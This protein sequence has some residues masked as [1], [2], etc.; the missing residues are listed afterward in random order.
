MG[1]YCTVEAKFD[2]KMWFNKLH[3]CAKFHQKV[4]TSHEKAPT[5]FSNFNFNVKLSKNIRSAYLPTS[6]S[7]VNVISCISR[8]DNDLGPLINSSRICYKSQTTC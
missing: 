7:I 4:K 5:F 2:R 6:V 1:I 8:G 3:L